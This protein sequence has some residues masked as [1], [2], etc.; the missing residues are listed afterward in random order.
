M[1]LES[2]QGKRAIS[3]RALILAVSILVVLTTAAVAILRSMSGDPV[4]V[5][6]AAFGKLPSFGDGSAG[7]ARAL[8]VPEVDKSIGF[9]VQEIEYEWVGGAFP[10]FPDRM[11]VYQR[12]NTQVSEV[13]AIRLAKNFGLDGTMQ[14]E[15]G[16]SSYREFA[17]DE[18]VSNT[19][20]GKPAAEPVITPRRQETPGIYTFFDKNKHAYLYID[21]IDGR[22]SY[23]VEN[24]FDEAKNSPEKLPGDPEAKRIAID[25][26][27]S[28]D[29]LHQGFTG[30]FIWRVP[31][32]GPVSVKSSSA[33]GNSDVAVEA[34]E[35][36]EVSPPQD[37][38]VEIRFGKKLG[39]YDLV[40]FSGEPSVYVATVTIGPGGMILSASGELQAGLNRSHYPLINVGDAFREVKK[41]S[42]GPIRTLA[43]PATAYVDLAP[44][45]AGKTGSAEQEVERDGGSSGEVQPGNSGSGISPTP[46]TKDIAPPEKVVL[47]ATFDDVKTGY[48]LVRGHEGDGYY[49][50][51]YVFSGTMTG[52]D[53]KKSDYAATVPAVDPKYMD[54]HE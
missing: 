5:G 11:P 37:A 6:D 48:V 43:E 54:K 13:E 45:Q 35:T 3:N 51:A 40:E 36:I 47:K 41:G 7:V 29:L 46:P 38:F 16:P 20:D 42:Y 49:V 21:S 34:V 15:S 8:G 39:E 2:K 28:K 17:P 1:T 31:A 44:A 18:P 33:V 24:W 32:S 14:T 12:Q 22:F 50:P 19:G 26:L 10:E 30:P 53:G 23:S 9:A 27:K 25:F 52:P 4:I